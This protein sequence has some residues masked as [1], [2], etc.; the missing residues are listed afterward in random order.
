MPCRRTC[1]TSC[2]N[3]SFARFITYAY[4][5]GNIGVAVTPG[6]DQTSLDIVITGL[7]TNDNYD[8]SIDGGATWLLSAQTD[9]TINIPDLDPDTEYTVLIRYNCFGGKRRL[10]TP[11]VVETFAVCAVLTYAVGTKTS[12][13]IPLNTIA[14]I[15]VGDT[16]DVSK[17]GGATWVAT[18][19]TGA[20]YTLTG[21]TPATAYSIVLR[22]NCIAGGSTSTAPNSQSTTA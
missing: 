19:Q 20:T 17:D 1:K 10:Q 5:C 8:V 3:I 21:L 18:A 4:G 15:A 16:Y 22:K 12:T 14:T 6:A 11:V 13:T 7:G 9:P 2:N